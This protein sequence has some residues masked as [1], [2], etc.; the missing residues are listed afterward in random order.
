MKYIY[1]KN[2]TEKCT[3]DKKRRRQILHLSMVWCEIPIYS[4]Y[5][6]C[7]ENFLRQLPSSLIMVF[8][9][10]I[11]RSCYVPKK[12]FFSITRSPNII[13][14]IHCCIKKKNFYRNIRI[15]RIR[16]FEMQLLWYS[17]NVECNKCILGL[18]ILWTSLFLI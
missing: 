9:I 18:L 6:S 13:N 12:R 1:G 15:F 5:F 7:F 8:L 14:K 2:V 11:S 4:I 10:M 3:K 16:S 17:L